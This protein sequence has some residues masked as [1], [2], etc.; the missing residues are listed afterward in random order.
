M[1]RPLSPASLI[2]RLALPVK[3]IVI[4]VV[5]LLVAVGVRWVYLE[6][7]TC[8]VGVDSIDGQC[9]GVTDGRVHL[10]PELAGV[11]DK[12]RQENEEV[13]RSELPAV[14]VVYLLPL[15]KLG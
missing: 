10:T 15:P 8:G 14:S 1:A 12:I 11:L 13:D 6:L 2:S 3:A 9:I 4:V 5:V 7:H